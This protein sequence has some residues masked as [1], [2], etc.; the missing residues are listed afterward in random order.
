MSSTNLGQMN[1]TNYK[2]AD[3]SVNDPP[4]VNATRMRQ[5][6][7]PPCCSRKCYVIIVYHRMSKSNQFLLFLLLR[8]QG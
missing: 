4:T 3:T 2:T 5:V 7:K 8:K 1:E 6:N